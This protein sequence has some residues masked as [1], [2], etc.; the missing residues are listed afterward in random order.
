MPDLTSSHGFGGIRGGMAPF[1]VPPGAQ[2]RSQGKQARVERKVSAGEV[3]QEAV[4]RLRLPRPVIRTSP[5]ADFTQVVHVPT[6]MWVQAS[7]WESVSETAS[8]DGVT[9]TATARPRKAVWSM[10][11]GASVVCH[12]PGTPYSAR[13]GA[14]SSS[15]DC[16]HTY[17]RAS[18]SEPDGKYRVKVRVTWDVSWHGAGESGVVPG[19]AMSAERSLSVDEVQAVVTA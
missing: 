18:L 11:D 10:G 12:G 8:V 2:G 16:G 7:S 5:D 3:A 4:E 1:L 15:P 6:W 14:E 13:F 19:M 17:R 9:V